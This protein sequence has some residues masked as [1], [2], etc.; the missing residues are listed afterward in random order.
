MERAGDVEDAEDQQDLR[1]HE[2]AECRKEAIQDLRTGQEEADQ[3]RDRDR[4]EAHQDDIADDADDLEQALKDRVLERLREGVIIGEEGENGQHT[5]PARRV[6]L[7]DRLRLR[8]SYVETTQDQKA[9]L[10]DDKALDG[11][12]EGD[13][14]DQD[15]LQKIRRQHLLKDVHLGSSLRAR[16][17]TGELLC[18][19]K[20]LRHDRLH[21]ED[22]LIE[23]RARDDRKEEDIDQLHDD[24]EQH[25]E[26]E[27]PG[28]ILLIVDT[29]AE[30]HADEGHAGR[31]DERRRQTE[32]HGHQR[33]CDP[34]R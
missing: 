19:V 31:V 8:Y 2:N 17:C 24:R 3:K 14:N 33:G 9:E 4:A 12:G 18:R 13:G 23:R 1:H 7:D 28:H 20:G 25:H 5:Q 30:D 29:T 34:D 11:T 15:T 21:L 32:E 16:S 6:I 26:K 22:I 10:I 27:G